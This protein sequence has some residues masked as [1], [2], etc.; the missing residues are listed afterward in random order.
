[1][2]GVGYALLSLLWARALM[3]LDVE[4]LEAVVP[5]SSLVIVPCVV[6]Y[7]LLE[8]VVGVVATASLPLMSGVLLLLCLREG[9]KRPSGGRPLWPMSATVCMRSSILM[10]PCSFP[11]L[12]A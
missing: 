6:V 9:A 10:S 12:P 2:T 3:V 8:G 11:A 5:L 4:E 1:M 7:P